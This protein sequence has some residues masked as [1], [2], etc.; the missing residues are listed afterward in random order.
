MSIH[1]DVENTRLTLW[2]NGYVPVPIRTGQK[3]PVE[4][5]WQTI[6]KSA[7]EAAI[8]SWK[9]KLPGCRSTGILTGKIVGADIDVLDEPLACAIEALA[10][11]VLGP[12][13]LKRIGLSPKRLLGYRSIEPFSKID[14]GEFYIGVQKHKIEILAQG[15]QFVAYGIHPDTQLPYEWIGRTPCEVPFDQLQ[16]V[17]EAQFRDFVSKAKALL[18][19][20]GATSNPSS[21]GAIAMN[22][23]R[24]EMGPSLINQ[25]EVDD[26]FAGLQPRLNLTVEQMQQI[27]GQ[28][29]PDIGRNDWLRVG[30]GLHHETHGDDIGFAIWNDWSSGGQKYRGENDLRRQW[31]S[32]GRS[33][34]LK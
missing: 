26:P 16:I 32:F 6:Y 31:K 22:D 28:L 24:P 10:Y 27:L 13:P 5:N 30:M 21:N 33:K 12:S 29:D 1:E 19:R 15:Q 20:A 3:F 2:R 4:K 14:G 23:C 17:T 34:G 25:S 7:D 9:T 18:L 11:D 8:R